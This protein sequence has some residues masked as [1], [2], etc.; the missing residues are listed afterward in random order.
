MCG[1][2]AFLP[3]INHCV[4]SASFCKVVNARVTLSEHGNHAYNMSQVFVWLL[5]KEVTYLN[6][7]RFW[8]ISQYPSLGHDKFLALP[9][10]FSA[11]SCV[12]VK[13]L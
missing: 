1:W 13:E 5:R 4:I 10:E 3:W 6:F 7:S 9:K 11:V 2:K 8:E 12:S